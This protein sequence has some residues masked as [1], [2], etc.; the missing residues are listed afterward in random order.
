MAVVDTG[1]ILV[2]Y[3]KMDNTTVLEARILLS[4]KREPPSALSV[5]AKHFK[6]QLRVE[7]RDFARFTCLARCRWKE[8]FPS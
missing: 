7:E 5:P 4:R 2:Y 3:E 1:G 6:I 8:A